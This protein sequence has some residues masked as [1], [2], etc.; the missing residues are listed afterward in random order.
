MQVRVVALSRGC[1]ASQ[2]NPNMAIVDTRWKSLY[3][4]GGGLI[5]VATMEIESESVEG[6]YHRSI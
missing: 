3:S 2:H 1:I 4:A 5:A 6:A